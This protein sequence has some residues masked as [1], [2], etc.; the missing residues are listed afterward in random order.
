MREKAARVI[1]ALTAVAVVVGIGMTLW[2]N[3]HTATI[4][5]EVGAAHDPTEFASTAGKVISEFFYFT[6]WSNV[7][8]GVTSFMLALKPN[9]DGKLFQV[10]RVTSLVMIFVTGIVFNTVLLG[11]FYLPNFFAQWGCNLEHMIVPLLA[12]AGWLLYGP[13][14]TLNR[15]NLFGALA[16]PAAW[17]VFTLIVGLIPVAGQVNDYF[18]P[19]PFV[20]VAVIG[21]GHALLN[22]ALVLVMYFGIVAA[23][24]GLDKVLPKQSQRPT[25]RDVVDAETAES[26]HVPAIRATATETEPAAVGNADTETDADTEGQRQREAVL[27]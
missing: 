26:D 23:V 15:R 25:Q 9:R 5:H 21:Y 27:I 13:R 1:F 4:I 20:D 14:L 2:S 8:I 10:L 12:L 11:T 16:I 17:V 24:L 7:L 6:I 22:M 18:Y 19:Y 3:I